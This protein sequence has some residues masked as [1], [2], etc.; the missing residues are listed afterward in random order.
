MISSKSKA[1]AILSRL[2]RDE[3][4]DELLRRVVAPIGLDIG[5]E[6]P[7]EIAIS[8]VAQIIM[9]RKKATGTTLSIAE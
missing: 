3:V 8:M 4:S 2:R 9:Q 5:A 7:T 6:T 1:K